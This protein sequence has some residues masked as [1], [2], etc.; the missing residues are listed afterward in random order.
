LEDDGSDEESSPAG[1]VGK[2]GQ[3]LSSCGRPSFSANTINKKF[4][5]NYRNNENTNELGGK[6]F[7]LGRAAGL[8]AMVMFGF[9]VSLEDAT[10][11]DRQRIFLSA[12][13]YALTDD[14]I[15]EIMAADEV[16]LNLYIKN[17]VIAAIRVY[18]Y[19]AGDVLRRIFQEEVFGPTLEDAE[20]QKH[21]NLLP[22]QRIHAL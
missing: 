16:T 8:A 5:C 9:D 10:Y 21:L 11:K 14:E 4:N 20:L 15:T 7:N 19:E 12:A 18:K 13:Y 17:L 2:T 3:V 1:K 22:G 6:L